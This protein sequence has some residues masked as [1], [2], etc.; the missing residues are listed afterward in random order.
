M[1]VCRLYRNDKCDYLFGVDNSSVGSSA[2]RV[3]KMQRYGSCN[4]VRLANKVHLESISRSIHLSAS[5]LPVG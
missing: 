1:A 2:D 3:P 5:K 4:V